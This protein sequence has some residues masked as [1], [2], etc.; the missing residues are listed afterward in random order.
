MTRFRLILAFGILS[1]ARLSA[2][3]DVVT[4][5][6]ATI[7]NVMQTDGVLNSPALSNPGW[8]TRTI[9]MMN[10]AIYDSFQAVNRTHTPL[11][12]NVNAPTASREAAA[13]QAAYDIILECYPLQQSILDTALTGPSG[14]LTLLPNNSAKTAGIALG[15]Q[16]AQQYMLARA[17]DGANTSVPYIA[18]TGLGQWAPDP[19]NPS[20]VAWGPQ[21]GAVPTFVVR[22]S[23][24]LPNAHDMIN[25]LTPPPALNSP[26]Y[27][28]AFNQVEN[29]GALSTYGPLNTP[30]S[31]TAEQTAIGLFWAYDRSSMG[32]PPVLFVRNMEDIAAAVGNSPEQN[33]RMFA[34]AS[35]AIADAAIASWDA[36]FTQ[37][38]WRPVAAIQQAGTGGAG[39][40]DG[41]PDTVADT[42]WRPLGAPGDDPGSFTDDFTPPF[43]SWTS[44]HATMAGALFKSIELFYGTNDFAIAD[45]NTGVDGVTANY[46][47]TSEEAGS[48]GSR[49]FHSFTQTG[50][51]DVGLENSPE[52]ENGMSRVYLGIHWIFDQRDGLTLGNNIAAFV[53]ANAFQAVSVPE[54][55]TTLL[56]IVALIGLTT[57]GHRRHRHLPRR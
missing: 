51:L 34:M 47:L 25:A 36:K 9:A 44:G 48:G 19:W 14:T 26:E 49:V 15:H 46:T 13:A 17:S 8:S 52:G 29:Y 28:A 43:P 18:P 4:D 30:T 7:R 39:D 45:A 50:L 5:W 40:A 12:V 41:N 32:P 21:Y 6:N 42:D 31:R 56:A 1:F 54:P 27:T 35:V 38:Y 23:A 57:S 3:A 33:A 10:G 24:N 16:I 37:N 55:G 2:H 11:M 53:S 22:D 20:Q